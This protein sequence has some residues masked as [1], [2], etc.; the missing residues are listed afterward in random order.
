N[1]LQFSQ[2][3]G[4]KIAKAEREEQ[5]FAVLFID[6]DRFKVI[7]D[8]LGHDAGDR[9]LAETGQRI[10]DCLRADDVVARLGGDEFVVVLNQVRGRDGVSRVA[11]NLLAAIAGPTVLSGHECR[12]S[13][14]IGIAI[15]PDH[16]TDEQTLTKRADIAMYE[17][18]AEGKNGFRFYSKDIKS[19]SIE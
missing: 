3:L 8:T 18:K 9:F 5:K 6:L 12:T 2:I 4:E 13:G 1:R 7:N 19:Q 14:S 10:T 16:G 11:T 15:Y 17:A